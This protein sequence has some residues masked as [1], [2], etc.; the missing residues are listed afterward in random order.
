MVLKSGSRSDGLD[1]GSLRRLKKRLTKS[2]QWRKTRLVF[3]IKRPSGGYSLFACSIRF[4]HGEGLFGKLS[5]NDTVEPVFC[6]RMSPRFMLSRGGARE[7]LKTKTVAIVGCG[8][9]GG[10]VS[11]MLA[12]SGIESATLVDPDIY[13]AENLYRHILPS[14]TLGESGSKVEKLKSYLLS[15]FPHISVDEFPTSYTVWRE[16][17]TLDHIDCMIVATGNPS[18]ER[19][20]CSDIRPFQFKSFVTGVNTKDSFVTLKKESNIKSFI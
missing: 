19:K 7:S 6:S 5:S 11:Y 4:V 3:R 9:L 13:T 12:Q 1:S 8:S 20:I 18:I 2:N 14:Y 17:N 10:Y 16:K 15:E